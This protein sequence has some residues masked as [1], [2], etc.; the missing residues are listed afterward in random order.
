[1]TVAIVAGIVLVPNSPRSLF[2]VDQTSPTTN[3]V[4]PYVPEPLRV[5]TV[6]AAIYHRPFCDAAKNALVVHGKEKRINFYTRQQVAESGRGPDNDICMSSVFDCPDDPIEFAATE[7]DPW[8]GANLRRTA[9]IVDGI[10][11]ELAGKTLCNLQNNVGIFVD[12]PSHCLADGDISGS[13]TACDPE[14]CQ[15]CRTQGPNCAVACDGCV[16]VTL[17][18]LNKVTLGLGDGNKDGETNRDDY[19]HFAECFSGAGAN[20]ST[21][22]QNVFDWD[23][24]QDV[25]VQDFSQFADVQDSG[26]VTWASTNF[27]NA[28]INSTIIE[29]PLRVGTFGAAIYHRLD[30]PSVN[31]SWERNGIN[32]R[33]DYYTWDA[34]EATGRTP[35]TTVCFAG[36]RGNP[37]GS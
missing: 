18:V 25:D 10:D 29:L 1:M 33:E 20:A 36:S 24:D 3:P 15:T 21:P 11:A 12:D 34:V 9:Y 37:D 6:G 23:E 4:D 7:N 35:D 19:L 26:N 32:L 22:C 2:S 8:C 5:G 17:A 13:S 27:P 31:A 30:C 16:N 14:V 28:S